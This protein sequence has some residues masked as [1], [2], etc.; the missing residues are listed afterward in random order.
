MPKNL[1]KRENMAIWLPEMTRVSGMCGGLCAGM[2]HLKLDKSLE[3]KTSGLFGLCFGAAFVV[4]TNVTL[5][6]ID[7]KMIPFVKQFSEDNQ[8]NVTF[9]LS[10]LA[11]V[12]SGIAALRLAKAA[13]IFQ[14]T[15]MLSVGCLTFLSAKFKNAV[16][17]RQG[18]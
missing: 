13:P 6:L 14:P 16:E 8:F 9:V 17:E 11:G 5:N 3:V 15:I 2:A 10:S 4:A 18:L 1:S 7:R 12:I